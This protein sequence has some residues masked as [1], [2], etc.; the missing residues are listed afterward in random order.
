MPK[1]TKG[2]P[3]SG[4]ICGSKNQPGRS[5]GGLPWGNRAQQQCQHAVLF[6]K[7]NFY[8]NL[9]KLMKTSKKLT[10]AGNKSQQLTKTDKK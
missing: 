10:K 2:A 9:Q 5:N 7:L 3:G 4:S 1:T 6:R 8:K